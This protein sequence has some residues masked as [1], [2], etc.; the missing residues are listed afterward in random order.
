MPI[1]GPVKE[2]KQGSSNSQQTLRTLFSFLGGVILSII[3]LWSL[4]TAI[5]TR[6]QQLTTSVPVLQ[7]TPA[8]AGSTCEN[9]MLYQRPPGPSIEQS[10]YSEA[11]DNEGVHALVACD[12]ERHVFTRENDIY[13]TTVTIYTNTKPLMFLGFVA[14]R[15]LICNGS[16]EPIEPNLEYWL[17]DDTQE[18]AVAGRGYSLSAAQ[19][20]SCTPDERE[21]YTSTI[22]F[23]TTIFIPAHSSVSF[24]VVARAREGETQHIPFRYQA[25]GW[26]FADTNTHERIGFFSKRR[27]LDRTIMCEMIETR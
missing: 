10:E 12:S 4:F 23:D 1:E 25:D 16:S 11:L 19:E 14:E 5:C 9:A 21:A 15:F 2:T 27:N 18:L 3:A 13:L 17:L 20:F 7:H 26:I 22:E 6:V 8:V 24:H